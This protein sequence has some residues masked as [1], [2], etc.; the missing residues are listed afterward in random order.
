MVDFAPIPLH[1]VISQVTPMRPLTLSASY[2]VPADEITTG[3][4]ATLMKLNGVFRR[5]Q[6]LYLSRMTVA[7]ALFSSVDEP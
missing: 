7:G 2:A 1:I 4:L 3:H 5:P 6:W